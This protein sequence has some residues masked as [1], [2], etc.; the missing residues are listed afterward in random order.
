MFLRLVSP[1]LVFP[2]VT[3]SAKLFVFFFT[4]KV[5]LLS[6]L[7]GRTSVFEF[8]NTSKAAVATLLA[9]PYFC[10]LVKSSPVIVL[11]N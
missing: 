9:E 10:W 3:E 5:F 7:P 6:L 1:A 2:I 4:S 11:L 8:V